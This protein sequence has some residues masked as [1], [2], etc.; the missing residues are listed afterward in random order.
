MT[1]A[2]QLMIESL[3]VSCLWQLLY[4]DSVIWKA[5]PFLENL[6]SS[7]TGEIDEENQQSSHVH[8]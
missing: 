4:G 1:L 2:D 7:F 8:S 6:T 5:R 3:I